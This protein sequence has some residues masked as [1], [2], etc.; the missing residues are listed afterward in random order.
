MSTLGPNSGGTVP[1]PAS[2]STAHAIAAAKLRVV[3]LKAQQAA[4]QLAA[5]NA[6]QLEADQNMAPSEAIA[7]QDAKIAPLTTRVVEL[8]RKKAEA[9]PIFPDGLSNVP[10]NFVTLPGPKF[11]GSIFPK[12]TYKRT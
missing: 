5:A 2:G 12:S 1:V 7:V 11:R 4:E 8:E 6:R 3:E 10:T 9:S